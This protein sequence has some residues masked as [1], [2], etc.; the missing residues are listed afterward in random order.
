MHLLKAHD[1]SPVYLTH[2]HP[3]SYAY[4]VSAIPIYYLYV[5]RIIDSNYETRLGLQGFSRKD[6]IRHRGVAELERVNDLTELTNQLPVGLNKRRGYQSQNTHIERSEQDI[7]LTVCDYIGLLY[8]NRWLGRIPQQ[9]L[10]DSQSEKSL[11]SM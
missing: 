4:K 7:G 10:N 8:T 3:Q 2:Q 9:L 6:T 1:Y 11:Y 5:T